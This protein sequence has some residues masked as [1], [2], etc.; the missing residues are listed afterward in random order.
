MDEVQ[1]LPLRSEVPVELTWDTTKVFAD[2][3]DFEKALLQ[4]QEHTAQI[5]ELAGTLID[6]ASQLAQEITA[7]LQLYRQLEKVYVYASLKSDQD[8]KNNHYQGYQAQADALVAQVSSATAFLEP[9]ILNIDTETLQQYLQEPQLQIYQHFIAQITNK[10]DH[11]LN[12]EQEALLAGASDIFNTGSNVFNVLTNA[13]LQFPE[14]Q[15]VQ[16]HSVQLSDSVYGILLES[17]APEVRKQAFAA[18]YQVY[19]QFKNTLASSL[20]GEVKKNNYYAKVHH[21]ASA[22]QAALAQNQIPPV[23]YDTLITEV[24]DHLDLL[25]RYVKLRKKVLRLP[26]LHMYDLYTPLVGEAPIKYTLAQAKQTA[27]QALQPLGVD[28][29]QR[30]QEIFEHRYIDVVEN[31]GKRS[32]AY[33][34]GS[35]DT[36]PYILLNWQDNLDNLYTLVHE[37]GHSVHSWYTRNT[38]PYVYGDYPIFLAEIAST[39]NENL[40]TEYLLQTQ[41]DPHIR[42]YVLN[43]YLDGFKGTVFRQTQFAEFEHFIHQADAQGKPLTAEFMSQ[44]YGDLN[45]CYYGIDVVNDPQ[46]ALEWARIPHFYMNYYVYQY[47]TGFAAASALSQNLVHNNAVAQIKY[48]DYL[49]AGSSKYPLEIMNAAGVDMTKPDYLRQAFAVFEQ[50]LEELEKLL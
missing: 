31:Q 18:L 48:L 21:Y 8:T 42:A 24:N 33:S 38:Q 30:V 50:R 14:I 13:D 26:E 20:A 39:T 3:V 4:V 43:Y 12:A 17:S 34:G 11:V 2:D 46:I 23:V 5:G 32:G 36:P 49:K 40:L 47:A 1:Q 41:S 22:R 35:Y 10:R 9:A 44:Y 29:L 16:G 25:H 19:G 6:S 45:A 37:T 7:V 27:K 15:D 28:Y